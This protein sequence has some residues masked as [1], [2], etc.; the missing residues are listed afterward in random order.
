MAASS[1]QKYIGNLECDLMLVM[2]RRRR[3][4]LSPF[5]TGVVL[6][7][8]C[9]SVIMGALLMAKGGSRGGSPHLHLRHGSATWLRGWGEGLVLGQEQSSSV[10]AGDLPA[11]PGAL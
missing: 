9:R 8:H 7:W 4:L 6:S 1:G 5:Q 11:A 3:S 2:R 10:L